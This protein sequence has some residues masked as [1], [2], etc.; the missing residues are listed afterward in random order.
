MKY[1]LLIIFVIGFIGC[2]P[3][4]QLDIKALTSELDSIYQIDQKYRIE[5]NDVEMNTPEFSELY[6]KMI[7]VDTSNQRRI[8]EIINEIGGYPGKSL[9]GE[10][11]S[12][13]AFYVLQHSNDSI[14]EKYYDMI[15]EAAQNNELERKLAAMYQDRYLMRKGQNQI[16]GTQIRTEYQT[17]SI[18]GERI[19][20]TFVWPIADTTKIDS[21]RLTYGMQP[22]EEYLARFG[23]SRWN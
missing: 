21:I 11:A 5:L 20:N 6:K 18:S 12:K 10:D 2:Q 7:T 17:D 4:K 13:T 1:T 3:N 9:V 22:L 23:L 19:A 16:Y 15:I 8:I 14:Q